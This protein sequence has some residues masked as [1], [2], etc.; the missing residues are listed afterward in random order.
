MNKSDNTTRLLIGKDISRTAGL[1]VQDNSL[2][3]FIADGEIVVLSDSGLPLLPGATFTDSP[4][5]T[6]VQGRGGQNSLQPM[7]SSIKIDGSTIAN[8]NGT[9]YRASAEQ[10]S[11]VGYNT[12]TTA[13]SIDAQPFTTYKLTVNYKHDKEMFSEQL[14]K[15]VYT[16]ATGS[17]A[18]QLDIATQLAALITAEEMHGV[19]ATVVNSGADY[20]I[21]LDGQ[22]LDQEL[23][24][25][26]WNVMMFEV[27]LGTG[28]GATTLTDP[29]VTADKGSG[30]SEQVGELEWFCNGFD[31]II[32]RVNF[33]APTSKADTV[34]G[35]TYDMISIE[36]YD[37][38]ENYVI[39]G[40]KPAK[41]LTVIALPDTANQT[42]DVL[43]QLNP[44]LASVVKPQAAIAV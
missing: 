5:I 24:R 4:F 23:P 25:F 38:S 31:G 37:V 40:T 32:N 30:K 34:A 35:E 3:T 27:S 28:F 9:S 17:T 15:R 26:K 29:E 43:A 14:L 1:Q 16:Y 13:G 6:I 12:V 33:P 44:W 19:T 21:R 8:S 2:S 22:A 42:A 39:S 36:S 20:G 10:Q 41:A 7:V 11:F 18:T